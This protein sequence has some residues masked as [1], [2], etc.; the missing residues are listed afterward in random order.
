[1]V[2][3]MSE[4]DLKGFLA[5]S[6]GKSAMLQETHVMTREG[7]LWGIPGPGTLGRMIS[8]PHIITRKPDRILRWTVLVL[9]NDFRPR[10]AGWPVTAGAYANIAPVS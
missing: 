7:Y 1:M 5:D 6:G 9:W 10:F 4:G 2:D 8:V 3:S